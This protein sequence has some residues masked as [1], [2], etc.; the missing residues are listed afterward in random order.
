MGKRIFGLFISIFMI[1]GGLSGVLVL[2]GTE[3]STALVV[4]A[5]GFLIWDI[6]GMVAYNKNEQAAIELANRSEEFYNTLINE[7]EPQLLS[8]PR[9]ID[10]YIWTNKSSSPILFLN[11][12]DYGEISLYNR[13]RTLITDRVKNALLVVGKDECKSYICFEV[14]GEAVPDELQKPGI[15]I[16]TTNT[17]NAPQKFFS[18]FVTQNSGLTQIKL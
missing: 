12:Q 2:R 1:C 11:G 18:I 13:H 5:F 8:E 16:K 7:K 9:N 14:I 4:V 10:I 15:Q 17:S 6:F 3:S